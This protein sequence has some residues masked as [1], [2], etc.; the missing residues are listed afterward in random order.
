MIDEVDRQI[1]QLRALGFQQ[2][3]IARRLN[4]SQATVSQRLYNIN[5]QVQNQDPAK[6]F[7]TLILGGATIYLLAK[8]IEE[9]TNEKRR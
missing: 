4:I 7:W 8:V 5:Q 6:A 2:E 3:E 9:L 1:M